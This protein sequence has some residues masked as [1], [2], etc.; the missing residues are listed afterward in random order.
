MS[1]LSSFGTNIMIYQVLMLV[2]R[3]QRLRCKMTR[4]K[5]KIQMLDMPTSHS[6]QWMPLNW[7]KKR[8]KDMD[9]AR[10]AALWRTYAINAVA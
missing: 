4:M 6:D 3:N 9:L 2:S 10:D 8:I 7:S 1:S 5:T